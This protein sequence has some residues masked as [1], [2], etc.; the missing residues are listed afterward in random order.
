MSVTL[1]IEFHT[2]SMA[3]LIGLAMVV[4][5]YTQSY[6]DHHIQFI[7][8]VDDDDVDDDDAGE[9]EDE[10]TAFAVAV[11][12]VNDLLPNHVNTFVCLKA[13]STNRNGMKRVAI[14]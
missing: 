8:S 10:A 9:Y 7:S 12:P 6:K 11:A 3:F 13:R 2:P 14:R 4:Q 5:N 1:V